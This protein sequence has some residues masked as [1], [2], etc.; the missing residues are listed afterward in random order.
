[1]NSPQY[2]TE[3]LHHFGDSTNNFNQTNGKWGKG[4]WS[5]S[6]AGEVGASGL[7]S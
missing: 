7:F 6:G 1:M 4:G 2:Y 5:E 3:K